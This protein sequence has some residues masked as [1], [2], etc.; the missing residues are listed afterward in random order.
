MGAWNLAACSF[1][2]DRPGRLQPHVV[3]TSLPVRP[4]PLVAVDAAERQ[5]TICKPRAGVGTCPTRLCWVSR[6][7]PLPRRSRPLSPAGW[8]AAAATRIRLPS[9]AAETDTGV[10]LRFLDQPTRSGGAQTSRR[11]FRQRAFFFFF[12]GAHGGHQSPFPYLHTPP[13]P[14]LVCSPPSSSTGTYAFLFPD[15][16]PVAVAAPVAGP[17]T[18]AGGIVGSVAATTPSPPCLL[19]LPPP[20]PWTPHSAF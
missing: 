3:S 13:L 1:A 8:P 10:P 12:S 18:F 4:E 7:W 16:F 11:Q 2:G 17:V 15:R 20:P 9:A 6:D 5:P 19:S 14:G